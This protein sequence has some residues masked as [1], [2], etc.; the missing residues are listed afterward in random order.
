MRAGVARLLWLEFHPQEP[1]NREAMLRPNGTTRAP[2]SGAIAYTFIRGRQISACALSYISLRFVRV[3][4]QFEPHQLAVAVTVEPVS[5][6]VPSS[7]DRNSII[8]CIFPTRGEE[9]TAPWVFLDKFA[10][11]QNREFTARKQGS[12]YRLQGSGKLERRNSRLRILFSDVQAAAS[13]VRFV[14]KS[15][16][17]IRLPRGTFSDKRSFSSRIN[18][19]P[20]GNIAPRLVKS[21]EIVHDLVKCPMTCAK[22]SKRR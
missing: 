13:E 15:R 3:V 1:N 2:N 12:P 6:A 8:S 9:S 10:N 18:I 11:Q 4:V 21:K 22:N 7:E 5:E 19:P 14:P 17:I 16:E 20:L